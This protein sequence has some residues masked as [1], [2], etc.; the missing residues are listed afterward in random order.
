MS[1][2]GG[3]SWTGTLIIL[4]IIIGILGWG[5]IETLRWAFSFVHISFG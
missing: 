4:A 2:Y 3:G 5:I 1:Y